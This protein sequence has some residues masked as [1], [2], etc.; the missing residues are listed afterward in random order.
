MAHAL[1]LAE[2]LGAETW[3]VGS[4]PS[5]RNA[6]TITKG[7]SRWR[8]VRRRRYTSIRTL[9]SAIK[10][11]GYESIAIEV[12][13]KAIPYLNIDPDRRALALFVGSER[14]GM[15]QDI[16]E[17]IETHVYVPMVGRSSCLSVGMAL[18]VVAYH[19]A[20]TRRHNT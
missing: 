20:F 2:A 11:G 18:A 19:C 15:R 5:P 7:F 10:R 13:T 14:F 16:L 4:G 17:R 8:S 9:F 3:F 6:T 12:S 1:R